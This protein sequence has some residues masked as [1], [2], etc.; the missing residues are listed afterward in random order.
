MEAQEA[1]GF[2]AAVSCMAARDARK[3]QIYRPRVSIL[4]YE[5]TDQDLHLTR[6]NKSAIISK[7]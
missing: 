7:T 1:V 5:E 2:R 3:C 6:Q 4:R